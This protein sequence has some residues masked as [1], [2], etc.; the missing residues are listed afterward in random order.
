MAGAARNFRRFTGCSWP[1][2]FRMAALNAARLLKLDDRIGSIAVGKQ[3]N[4]IVFADDLTVS[5][6]FLNGRTL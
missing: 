1:E 4:L 6:S 2:L 3:A 5:Q